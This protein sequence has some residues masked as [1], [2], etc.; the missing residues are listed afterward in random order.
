MRY[1]S[2]TDEAGRPIDVRDPLAP[3]LAAIAAE[4][5]GSPEALAA[6]L[7]GL[8]GVFG[9]DLPQDPRFTGPVTA[10]LKRLFA[11]GSRAVAASMS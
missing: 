10:A 1:V 3:Q 11:E 9:E 8:T 4:A 2:G 6:A 5:G 7:L